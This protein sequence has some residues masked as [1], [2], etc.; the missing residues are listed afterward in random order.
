MQ[1]Q[2]HFLLGLAFISQTWPIKRGN[3]YT[4]MWAWKKLRLEL[5]WSCTAV[6]SAAHVWKINKGIKEKTQETFL[7]TIY[8]TSWEQ[9]MEDFTWKERSHSASCPS[10]LWSHSPH[11]ERFWR[12]AQRLPSP[13]TS[14]RPGSLQ[15]RRAAA[16]L[17]W[18]TR[19]WRCLRMWCVSLPIPGGQK[20]KHTLSF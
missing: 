18:S 1:T 14:L 3:N 12:V 9:M 11:R 15:T 20:T 16:G 2:P 7:V 4:G 17:D 8:Q 13:W 6:K 10:T 5:K 19:S